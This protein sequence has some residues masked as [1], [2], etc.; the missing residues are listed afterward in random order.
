MTDQTDRPATHTD[1]LAE[2]LAGYHRFGTGTRVHP[3]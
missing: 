3:H 1:A 2:L